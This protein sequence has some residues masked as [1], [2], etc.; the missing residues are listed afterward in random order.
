M[1][2]NLFFLKYV[3]AVLIVS[4][5][6]MLEYAVNQCD[7]LFPSGWSWF[8]EA[9]ACLWDHWLSQAVYLGQASW[10]MDEVFTCC[11]Q[12]CIANRNLS[13]RLQEEVQTIYVNIFFECTWSLVFSKVP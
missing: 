10:D 7:G 5:H 2:F 1:L 12:E 6:Y 11:A 9:R 4:F 3:S 8:S 13:E